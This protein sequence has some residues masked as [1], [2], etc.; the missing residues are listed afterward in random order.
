M[1]AH[2]IVQ[3]L[4]SAALPFKP[5]Q[6]WV[7]LW[8]QSQNALHVETLDEMLKSNHDA[9]LEDRRMDYVPLYVGDEDTVDDMAKVVRPTMIAR[10]EAKSAIAGAMFQ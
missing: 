7:L 4:V 9:F 1:N 10:A 2:A 8:S 5:R 3:Q 6:T